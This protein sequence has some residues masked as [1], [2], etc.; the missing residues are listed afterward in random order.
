M[1]NDCVIPAH[2]KRSSTD[3][4]PASAE[5]AAV[6]TYRYLNFDQ[7]SQYTEKADG[8]IFQTAV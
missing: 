7:L 5:L 6:D 2:N 1:F 8:V 3:R 4:F